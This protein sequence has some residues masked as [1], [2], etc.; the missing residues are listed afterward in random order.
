MTDPILLNPVSLLAS[1]DPSRRMDQYLDLLMS[2]NQRVN[3]VSR[4]TSRDRLARMA[5]EALL[6]AVQLDLRAG[7]YLDI[8]SGGGIPAIPILL[9]R[10]ATG[11]SLLVERTQKKAAT[12]SRIASGLDLKVEVIDRTFEELRL[13]RTFDL[14][15]L[16][17][18]KLTERLLESI[19]A[20]LDQEGRFI[21]YS[22]P[23]FPPKSC[24]V[25]R[26]PFMI[27]GDSA[28]RSFSVF[29]RN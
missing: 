20:V 16:S 27:E 4:E 24:L 21:Y 14:I 2:E 23:T 11:P 18:V 19:L 29:R 13:N 8:G 7:S 3:L 10:R 25:E 15:T 28:V 5:A 22:T 26:Y 9:S 6:P 12:L 17:Y 1:E